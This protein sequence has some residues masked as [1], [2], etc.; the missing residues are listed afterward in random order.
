MPDGSVIQLGSE[1][2]LAAEVLFNY[3][4]EFSSKQVLQEVEWSFKGLEPEFK[5]LL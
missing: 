5:R 1:R 3:S 4:D 2:R